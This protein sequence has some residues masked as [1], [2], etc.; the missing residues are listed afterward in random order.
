MVNG[1]IRLRGSGISIY[2]F[3][4]GLYP[5]LFRVGSAAADPI[6]NYQK[7]IFV[8]ILKNLFSPKLYR[9]KICRDGPVRCGGSNCIAPG[10]P[11]VVGEPGVNDYSIA[12]N[13]WQRVDLPRQVVPTTRIFL[14]RQS[15]DL[16]K[17]L[18]IHQKRTF[19]HGASLDSSRTRL[20]DLW[21]LLF[22]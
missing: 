15:H 11:A 18:C 9:I 14:Q 16:P 7:P 19:F 3:S 4:H 2:S 8:T 5:R 17:A 20:I 12:H 21:F 22:Q 6:S 10:L 13:P 1:S